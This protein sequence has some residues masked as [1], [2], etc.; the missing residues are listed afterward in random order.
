MISRTDGVPLYE[1]LKASLKNRIVQ[2]EYEPLSR[3]PSQVGL[4]KQFDVSQITVRRA[5]QEL[6]DEGLLFARPGSGTYVCERKNLHQAPAETSTVA[7]VFEDI[8]GGYP[9][10]KPLCTAIRE[11]CR[12]HD[13]VLQF[14]EVPVGQD[15]PNPARN[16]SIGHCIGAILVSPV[17]LEILSKLITQKTPY[18]LLHNDLCD[19][20][21]Y[22]VSCNYASGVVQ[23]MLHLYQ[24]GCRNLVLVTAEK[25]RYSAGQMAL[26]CQLAQ[27]ALEA[28]GLKCRCQIICTDYTEESAYRITK[29]LIQNERMPDGIIYASDQAAK[30]GVIALQQA[31]ISVPDQVAVV[32]FGNFLRPHE[33]TIEISSVDTHNEKTGVLAMQLLQT[34]I[35]GALPSERRV[36]VEPELV[37]RASSIRLSRDS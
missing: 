21:S 30:S 9:L 31:G 35:Q 34:M 5:I 26:G 11:E 8:V 32:G 3:L 16:L 28:N 25:S 37:I 12:K 20:S 14:I 13:Y 36:L 23:A 19:R 10:I 2:G 4:T 22:C 6:V 24:Q 27:A 17:D 15:E 29:E 7:I 33:S 18:V 1:Q